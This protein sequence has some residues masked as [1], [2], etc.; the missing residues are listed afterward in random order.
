M[1]FD[2]RLDEIDSGIAKVRSE[3]PYDDHNDAIAALDWLASASNDVCK[4]LNVSDDTA[5]I[6]RLQERKDTLDRLHSSVAASMK[7]SDKKVPQRHLERT[8]T[9]VDL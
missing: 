2:D 3:K 7:R 5:A 1:T 6:G 4:V 8:T 9:Q